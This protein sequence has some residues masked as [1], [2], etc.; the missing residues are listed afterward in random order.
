[1][2]GSIKHKGLRQFHQSGTRRGLNPQWA[3][4]IRDVLAFLD[5]ATCPEEMDIAGLN[6]HPLRGKYAGF[7]ALSITGNWRIIFRFE[8]GQPIDVDLVDYH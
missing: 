4:R 5:A 3:T 7:Y 2:I 6:L 8:N 1:M